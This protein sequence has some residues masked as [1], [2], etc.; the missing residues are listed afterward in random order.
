M[1]LGSVVVAAVVALHKP[2]MAS[3]RDVYFVEATG[4]SAESYLLVTVQMFEVQ[5]NQTR[6]VEIGRK[7]M[8]GAR[9]M[10][11]YP[12]HGIPDLGRQMIEMFRIPGWVVHNLTTASEYARLIAKYKQDNTGRD[13]PRPLLKSPHPGTH[14]RW[15]SCAMHS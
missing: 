5:L 10:S 8:T 2:I 6:I 1:G 4:S 13:R 12:D 14:L 3:D 7:V 11:A 9:W 15:R